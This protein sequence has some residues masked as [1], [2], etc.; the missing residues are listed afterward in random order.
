MRGSL[1]C[2][3][4]KIVE[5]FLRIH[6][7]LIGSHANGIIFWS[8]TLLS[9]YRSRFLVTFQRIMCCCFFKI[10]FA[11]YFLKSATSIGCLVL[12]FEKDVFD[13][14]FK[15]VSCEIF[16]AWGLMKKHLRKSTRKPIRKKVSYTKK[17]LKLV[18]KALLRIV[19]SE[20]TKEFIQWL[21]L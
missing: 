3:P 17:Y 1:Y 7:S 6:S 9:S 15:A 20:L 11:L 16:K 4:K 19:L 2:E 21:L 18:L 10:N 5:P 12:S 14:T 13:C 8:A